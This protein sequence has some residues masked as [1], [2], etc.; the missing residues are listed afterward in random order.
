MHSLIRAFYLTYP[1]YVSKRLPVV[2][3][4]VSQ[5][6]ATEPKHFPKEPL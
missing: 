6:L 4:W 2:P 5:R 3:E 1:T